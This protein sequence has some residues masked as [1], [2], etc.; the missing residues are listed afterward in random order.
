MKKT[1][2]EM[3]KWITGEVVKRK[4]RNTGTNSLRVPASPL[5]RV[6]FFILLFLSIDINLAYPEKPPQFKPALP[7]WRFEFPRDH[8]VHREFKTEWWYYT[9]HLKDPEG[10]TYGYQVTFF[11]VGLIPGL[12]PTGSS[13]WG[14]REVYLAH[15]AVTD[16]NNRAF[17]Y[18]EKTSRG[19]L[20][21]AGADQDRY[22]VWVENWQVSEEGPGHQIIA[23]DKDLGLS[24]NV[25]PTRS[26]I[27]HGIK[28]VSQKGPGAGQA[29]HYYSL[30]RLET[31]GNLKIKGKEIPVSGLSWMD[32][33]FGSN[34]LQESQVGWDWFSI[35][36]DNG[37]DLMIYLLRHSDGR[38]DPNSS[39][40][41]VLPDSKPIHLAH[42]EINLQ[43]LNYWKSARSGATYP[44]SWKVYLPQHDLKLDLIPLVA[45]QELITSKSTGVTYWE[46]AVRVK[47]THKGRSVEG[48]G[49]VELTG[50]DKRFKP[51]I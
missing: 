51:K 23:G 49:Y 44:A 16:V 3:M 42:P 27:I 43:V 5:L 46:G 4:S 24:L 11:R 25:I 29:S 28:G 47:G 30:T 38:V 18:Q 39:G 7:G 45:D 9:G 33:E 20:G 13:R 22:R 14:I 36:L 17:F 1:D 19:N 21:L 32:H 10:R 37:L 41:L 2:G 31:K 34:Q 8:R 6:I 35:Q 48:K 40:T 26:P 15:L 12:P 50:Y